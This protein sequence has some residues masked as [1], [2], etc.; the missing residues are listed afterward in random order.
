MTRFWTCRKC[1]TRS[2]RIKQ[3]CPDCGAKRPTSATATQKA[4]GEAYEVWEARYGDRCNICGR[5]ATTRRLHRDHEHGT[6]R[7]RGLLCFRCNSAL[8][9][10]MTSEWLRAAAAYLERAGAA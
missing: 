4:L 5:E 3:R 1:R 2:P 10:Y 6:G 7:P 8:R 9:S